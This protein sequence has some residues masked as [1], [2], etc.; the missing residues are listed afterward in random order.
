VIRFSKKRKI[1][2]ENIFNAEQGVQ[3]KRLLLQ[4]KFTT[5][6]RLLK[7]FGFLGLNRIL[8]V[9]DKIHIK[10]GFKN[11]GTEEIQETG[12]VKWAIF[13]PVGS[14][15]CRTWSLNIPYLNVGE[16]CWTEPEWLF[17]PEV[18]GH[19]TLLVLR[20]LCFIENCEIFE[21]NNWAIMRT[22]ILKYAAPYGLIGRKYALTD[23]SWKAS[24]YV[25][26]RG[27]HITIIIIMAT[28]I[29]A[30]LSFLLSFISIFLPKACTFN[31]NII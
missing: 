1:S 12:D 3:G 28:V 22:T 14:I 24:F 17:L 26:N 31:L 18:P 8:P 27:E 4:A 16:W 2:P 11:I 6:N 19:H 29:L 10:L 15:Q 23:G 20:P 7:A 30:F 5:D 21:P 25:L 13:Y 9:D